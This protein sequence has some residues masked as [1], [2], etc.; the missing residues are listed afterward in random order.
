MTCKNKNIPKIQKLIMLIKYLVN[1]TKEIEIKSGCMVKL[2]HVHI[3]MCIK[4][5]KL[6]LLYLLYSLATKTIQFAISKLFTL[7]IYL[8]FIPTE[9]NE[10][11]I[12]TI[13]IRL[14]SSTHEIT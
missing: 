8:Y 11:N 1:I 4:E 7:S 12:Y 5:C 13:S 2:V 3:T 9:N 6:C 14:F 10:I